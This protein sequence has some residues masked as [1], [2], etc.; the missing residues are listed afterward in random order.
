VHRQL[1]GHRA[2]GNL[3]MDRIFLHRFESTRRTV[4]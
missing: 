4:K 2:T 3:G 1:S